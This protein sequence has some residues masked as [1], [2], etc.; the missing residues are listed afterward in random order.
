MTTNRSKKVRCLVCN[1]ILTYEN[2]DTSVLV[3]HLNLEHSGL[4]VFRFLAHSQVSNSKI[5]RK[6]TSEDRGCSLEGGD[7]TKDFGTC[8]KS[9][10]TYKTTGSLD[11]SKGETMN[12]NIIE[13]EN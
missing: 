5:N 6:S 1:E 11:P 10:K 9:S 3:D 12:R 2:D 8:K 4:D 13:S 7:I